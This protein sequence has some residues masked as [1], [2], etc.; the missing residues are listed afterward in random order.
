MKLWLEEWHRSQHIQH[1]QEGDAI[2]K[3]AT[4]RWSMRI[5][6]LVLTLLL[7]VGLC[8]ISGTLMAQEA[9]VT[10]LMSKDLTDF[11]ARKA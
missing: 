10:S 2:M 1:Y 11:P 9:K 6:Y 7:S 8:L 5:Q 4:H 3:H